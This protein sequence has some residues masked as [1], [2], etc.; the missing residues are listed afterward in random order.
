M[1]MELKG[2]MKGCVSEDEMFLQWGE[3]RKGERSYRAI[4]TVWDFHLSPTLSSLRVP[5]R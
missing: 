1:S 2:K 3:L 4:T 5:K